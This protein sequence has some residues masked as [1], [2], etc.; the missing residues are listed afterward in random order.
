MTNSRQQ[1]ERQSKRPRLFFFLFFL[2]PRLKIQPVILGNIITSI[3][4]STLCI[5]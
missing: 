4:T 2:K 5:L 3:F 1:E